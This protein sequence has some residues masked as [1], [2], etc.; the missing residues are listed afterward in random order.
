MSEN[1]WE[2]LRQTGRHQDADL[3]LIETALALAESRNPSLSL[4]WYMA[5]LD[6]LVA[7]VRDLGPKHSAESSASALSDVMAGKFGYRGDMETYDDLANGDLAR[8]M[9]RRKGLPVALAVLYIHVGRAQ[10]WDLRGLAFPAHFLIRLDHGG[11]R[12]IV[13]PFHGGVTKTPLELRSLIKAALGAGSEL[14]PDVYAPVADRDVLFRLESNIMARQR[15]AGAINDALVT[16][17]RM[18]AFA[19]S[20]VSL[21]REK[22]VLEAQIGHVDRA[23]EALEHYL[24]LAE[25]DDLAHETAVLLQKLKQQ[26][27]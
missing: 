19:P 2:R 11:T 18:L 21:W 13:D 15:R 17:E 22:G 16:V 14:S 7:E 9:D 24:S 12:A 5:H 23:I 8:V 27:A 1:A 6:T 20:R 3:P 4:D 25:A 26:L 10:G